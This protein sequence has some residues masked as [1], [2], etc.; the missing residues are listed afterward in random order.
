[1]K[2]RSI[3][4]FILVALLSF[5][6]FMYITSSSLTE[7]PSNNTIEYVV[8]E[9][10][11]KSTSDDTSLLPSGFSIALCQGKSLTHA[12]KDKIYTFKLNND[13]FKPPTFL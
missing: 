1:M 2:I 4:T 7:N 13:L 6:V 11:I 5:S 3:S 9:S 8:D 12:F 10:D